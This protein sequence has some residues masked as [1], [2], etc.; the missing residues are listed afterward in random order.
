MKNYV[1]SGQSITFEAPEDLKSGQ[2]YILGDIFGIV[3]NDLKK[4]TKDHGE[5]FVV[6]VF[7]LT[8]DA[9][10]IQIGQRVYWDTKNTC[11]TGTP[12]PDSK[13]TKLVGVAAS[14][15]PEGQELV[16]VRLNGVSL[17]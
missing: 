14:N 17:Q 13:I 2:G 7:R 5:L 16:M 11:I 9:S 4:A 15:A 8:K 10:K 1:Y 6:G 3:S 12:N